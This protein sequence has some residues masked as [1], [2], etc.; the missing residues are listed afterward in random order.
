M[1]RREI[2]QQTR[3]TY[4]RVAEWGRRMSFEI[5][6]LPDTMQRLRE[7]AENFQKVGTRLE[8]SSSSL[9]ELTRLYSVTL[10]D[11]VRRSI[12]AADT[13]RGQVDRFGAGQAGSDVVANAVA[14]LQRTM[15]SLAALN[16]LWPGNRRSS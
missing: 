12:D 8:A 11:S 3:D 6:L 16:P 14:E 5:R 7:G 13:L 9:E 15:S 10:S 1:D 2:W 4:E